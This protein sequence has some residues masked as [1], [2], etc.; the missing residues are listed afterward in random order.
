MKRT[1]VVVLLLM[2]AVAAALFIGRYREHTAELAAARLTRA[3]K[4]APA[5]TDTAGVHRNGAQVSVWFL[6]TLPRAAKSQLDQ[7]VAEEGR[8]VQ[9]TLVPM[10]LIAPAHR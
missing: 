10:Q 1:T 7:I 9:V 2:V 6:D 8:P 3:L 5:L 4:G